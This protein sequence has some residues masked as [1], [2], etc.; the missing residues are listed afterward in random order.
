MGNLKDFNSP[1]SHVVV[2]FDQYYDGDKYI[3]YVT[4]IEK[5]KSK[6]RDVVML[7]QI[8]YEE[9]LDAVWQQWSLAL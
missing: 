3:I 1:S 9:R 6:R 4:A 8:V 2:A 7:N 5:E